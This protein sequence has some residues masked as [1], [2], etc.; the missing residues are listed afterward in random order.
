MRQRGKEIEMRKVGI[1]V[2]GLAVCV[3]VALMGC[4]TAKAPSDEEI[5][6]KLTN[7]S[8]AATKAKDIDKVVS[9]YSDSFTH[10]QFG[11]K[12]GL[13]KFLEDAKQMGYLDDIEIDMASAKTVVTGTTATVGPVLLRGTFGSTTVSYTCTKEKKV[14]WKITGMDLEM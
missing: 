14:G 1:A 3:A 5:I 2:L 8:I 10:G 7:D 4:Q 13:K 9:F 6:S 12:S 11:D